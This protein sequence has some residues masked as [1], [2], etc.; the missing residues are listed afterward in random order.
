MTV[1]AATQL[2]ER[3]APARAARAATARC[4]A[5]PAAPARRGTGCRRA[6]GG[7]RTGVASSSRRPPERGQPLGQPA[8]GLVVGKRDRRSAPARR[9]GRRRPA[10]GPLTS[11]SVT[12]GARS[13]GSSGPAPTTSRR[14]ASCTASTV[15]SPTG[16]PVARSASA[17]RCG[18]SV[19]RVAG[20]PLADLL[21][22]Q[23]SSRA[24]TPRGEISGRRARPGPGPPRGRAD[25]AGTAPGRAPGRSPRRARAGR[26][27]VARTG[28]PTDPRERSRR[29]IR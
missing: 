3:E 9:R 26:P 19:A 14:S 12:P 2:V 10:S 11:T 29:R 25:R 15:A 16:R 27:S 7:R 22:E 13:S 18:V 6:A 8:H 28:D 20:Q 1:P 5:G 24:I 23:R 21:D 4:R 17:T